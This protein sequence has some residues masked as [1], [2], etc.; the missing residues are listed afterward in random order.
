MEDIRAIELEGVTPVYVKD[1]KHYRS[2][3]GE[4]KPCHADGTLIP[5]PVLF[6]PDVPDHPWIYNRRRP[7]GTYPDIAGFFN[8][9][10]GGDNA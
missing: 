5:D 7:D 3:G 2:I 1:G 9:P 10:I 6:T 4:L 8:R